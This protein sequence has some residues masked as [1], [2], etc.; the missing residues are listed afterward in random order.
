MRGRGHGRLKI[1]NSGPQKGNTHVRRSS[2]DDDDEERK[3][4]GPKQEFSIGKVIVKPPNG[5]ER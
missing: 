3:V 5:K 4:G 1:S 2:D